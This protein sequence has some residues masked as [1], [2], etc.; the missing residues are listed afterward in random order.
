[1]KIYATWGLGMMQHSRPP[2]CREANITC[3]TCTN[4]VC[5]YM[6]GAKRMQSAVVPRQLSQTV[7]LNSYL[8]SAQGLPH[9]LNSSLCFASRG[10]FSGGLSSILEFHRDFLSCLGLPKLPLDFEHS[11]RLWGTAW[12]VI[13]EQPCG[14]KALLARSF[15]APKRLL[16]ALE[17][18]F[19][20]SGDSETL[21]Q[22]SFWVPE[23]LP[24][25]LWR[26]NQGKNI[27]VSMHMWQLRR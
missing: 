10:E 18:P 11:Q 21:L 1:M 5:I 26:E 15:R 19:W 7:I 8:E 25:R 12:A 22:W 4:S 20:A 23:A 27:S 16:W 17:Q 14:S 3:T 24:E 6:H 2:R 9:C 13:F